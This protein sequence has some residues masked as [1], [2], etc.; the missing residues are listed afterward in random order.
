MKS[1]EF[2]PEIASWLLEEQKERRRRKEMD[3]YTSSIKNQSR[4]VKISHK[5]AKKTGISKK[6]IAIALA[7]CTIL[8]STATMQMAGTR[9]LSNEISP[10]IGNEF[11]TDLLDSNRLHDATSHAF[12]S[13]T[14]SYIS[15]LCDSLEKEGYTADQIA[16]ALEYNKGVSAEHVPGTSL[17]GRVGAKISAFTNSLKNTQNTEKGMSR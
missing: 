9:Y 7:A 12:I 1:N 14:D 4:K 15:S 2:E 17:L 13:D 3:T 11:Y 16:V 6:K 5:S 8:G 10:K